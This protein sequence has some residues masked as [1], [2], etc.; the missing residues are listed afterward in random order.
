MKCGCDIDEQ[1]EITPCFKQVFNRDLAESGVPYTISDG[2]PKD[3]YSQMKVALSIWLELVNQK[4]VNTKYI[5]L[6]LV[7]ASNVDKWP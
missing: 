6:S 2:D 4:K 3:I 1:Y 7:W 5:F